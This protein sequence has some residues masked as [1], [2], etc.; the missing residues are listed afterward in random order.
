MNNDSQNQNKSQANVELPSAFG[1]RRFQQIDLQDTRTNPTSDFSRYLVN[2]LVVPGRVV[3]IFA[4]ML[5]WIS[6]SSFLASGSK[7]L[8]KLPGVSVIA[9]IVSALAVFLSIY[10]YNIATTSKVRWSLVY[11]WFLIV[12]GV[13]LGVR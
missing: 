13:L 5:I 1:G 2:Q 10:V 12:I 3:D 9:A 4:D 11:R 6:A 8:I 7:L